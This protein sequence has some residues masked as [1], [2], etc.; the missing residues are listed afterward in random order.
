MH[1]SRLANVVP[2]A[3]ERESMMLTA[4]REGNWAMLSQKHGATELLTDVNGCRWMGPVLGRC[5]EVWRHWQQCMPSCEGL[6]RSQ[7]TGVGLTAPAENQDPRNYRPASLTSI[8]GEELGKIM[9]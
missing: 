9:K 8:P 2:L 7:R 6:G 3:K 1:S 4:V 5:R